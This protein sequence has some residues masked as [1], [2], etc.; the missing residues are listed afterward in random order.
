MKKVV[1]HNREMDKVLYLLCY[2]Q[3]F[4]VLAKTI[5]R[6][7]NFATIILL[8]CS[9]GWG[10]FYKAAFCSILPGSDDFSTLEISHLNVPRTLSRIRFLRRFDRKVEQEIS[11]YVILNTKGSK[12]VNDDS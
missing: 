8:S 9:M 4:E 1:F 7:Y 5:L 6:D 12:M 3:K 11:N 2:S 10:H